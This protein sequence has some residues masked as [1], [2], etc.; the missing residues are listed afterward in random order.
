MKKVVKKSSFYEKN[1]EEAQGFVKKFLASPTFLNL[2]PKQK[3]IAEVILKTILT[4]EY[5][6]CAKSNRTIGAEAGA[7]KD[8]VNL[9][10]KKLAELGIV[11]ILIR[12]NGNYA[13]PRH[14]LIIACCWFPEIEDQRLKGYKIKTAARIHL[15]ECLEMHDLEK[16]VDLKN[17]WNRAWL[18][19]QVAIL[20][21]IDQHY[22]SDLAD[23]DIYAVED[24]QKKRT[25]KRKSYLEEDGILIPADK[26]ISKGYDIAQLELG[27]RLAT[28]GL[29]SEAAS[30]ADNGFKVVPVSVWEGQKHIIGHSKLSN[31]A[32]MSHKNLFRR[33]FDALQTSNCDS[34][35]DWIS[36]YASEKQVA[37]YK[38]RGT[39]DDFTR[40]LIFRW[41]KMFNLIK[42]INGVGIILPKDIICLDIDDA[43]LY[44]VV[45][46]LVPDGYWT[47]TKRGYHCFVRDSENKLSGIK[48]KGID[49]LRQGQMVVFDAA[50]DSGNSIYPYISGDMAAL[51]EIIDNFDLWFL[52]VEYASKTIT[53]TNQKVRKLTKQV[54]T[55]KSS[56][57][58]L[59]NFIEQGTRNNILFALGR[60]LRAKGFTKDYITI[61]I[62]SANE[63]SKLVEKELPPNELKHLISSVLRQ[64]DR[65]DFFRIYPLYSRHV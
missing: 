12:K 61:A 43:E 31:L 38:E 7:S 33:F 32:K 35:E 64:K 3:S 47:K 6:I 59:P 10:R 2:P 36:N 46:A 48:I 39:S 5:L 8:T 56:K 42:E 14:H 16:L 28:A 13:N 11:R 20:K 50:D 15:L 29:G 37:L 54:S 18:C 22:I 40:M 55:A 49:I 19:Q 57:F 45:K 30:L 60:S 4:S 17:L 51:P 62:E 9:V 52:N 1:V 25:K 63:N 53:T 27:S 34:F 65:P 41:R 24:E 21:S 26:K 44:P 58:K 23:A